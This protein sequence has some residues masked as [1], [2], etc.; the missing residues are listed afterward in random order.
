MQ[1]RE[2]VYAILTDSSITDAAPGGILERG[3]FETTP[4]QRPFIIYVFGAAR[5]EPR[6]AGPKRTDLIVYVH[7]NIGDYLVIDSTLDLIE[8]VLT[9]APSATD[10]S[11]FIQADFVERSQDFQDNELNTFYKFAR[12]QVVAS[13]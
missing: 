11:G 5:G 10:G 9:A 2:H 1:L 8:A 13:Q 4:Q 6:W 12:Y 7:D 3:S